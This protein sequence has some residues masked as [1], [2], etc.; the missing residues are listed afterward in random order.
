MILENHELILIL[1]KFIIIIQF[2]INNIS[3]PTQ[4]RRFFKLFL[5]SVT[6][7]CHVD[8][9]HDDEGS[10]SFSSSLLTNFS[11]MNFPLFFCYENII[12][13]LFIH[14]HIELLIR[15]LLCE[16][17]QSWF[18][19]ENQKWR[20]FCKKKFYLRFHESMDKDFQIF[21]LPWRP[22]ERIKVN[23]KCRQGGSWRN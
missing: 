5:T 18:R 16:S 12:F 15:L 6:V 23:L 21:L 22:I 13:H 11:D 14:H 20:G 1:G 8:G 3:F 7:L 10:R 4:W 17:T 2:H 9:F 19:S